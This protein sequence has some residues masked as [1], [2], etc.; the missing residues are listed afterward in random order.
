MTIALISLG[1]IVYAYVGY[2]LLIAALA[3]VAARSPV[4]DETYEPTV[5]VCMAVCDDAPALARKLDNLR[6]LDYPTDKLEIIVYS[7]GSTDG[8]DQVIAAAAAR[9]P[10]VKVLCSSEVRGKPHALNA[11]FAAAGGEVLLLTDAR[12][13]IDAAALR[14]LVAV[15]ADESVGCVSGALQLSGRAGAGVYWRYELWIRRNEA[16]FRGLVGATGALYAIRLRDAL[17]IPED[18]VLDDMWLPMQLRLQGKRSELCERARAYD[19]AQDDSPEFARK[20]RTLCGNYQLLW[21]MPR[22]LVPFLNP[23]WF[24]LVS[25]KVFR[26]LCPWALVALLVSSSI[27]LAGA[28]SLPAAWAWSVRALVA[29][30]MLVY[31]AALIGRYGGRLGRVARTFTVLNGAAVVGFWRFLRGAQPITWRSQDPEWKA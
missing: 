3:R 30:Q 23:S 22:L 10:R 21:R 17:S 13:L 9:D 19:R 5:S 28:D 12:Q 31:G 7:D 15:L 18:V 1:I 29:A 4:G 2:P 8:C 24:E 6:V 16:R 20:A 11:M 26:L 25:H 14:H 27:E